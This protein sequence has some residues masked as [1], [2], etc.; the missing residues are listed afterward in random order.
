MAQGRS[1][2]LRFAYPRSVL[3]GTARDVVLVRITNAEV[4][5]DSVCVAASR[6]RKW[7]FRPC[8]HWMSKSTT[9]SAGHCCA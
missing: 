1:S 7:R 2:R 8:G 4:I 6:A 3:A 5:G 9:S